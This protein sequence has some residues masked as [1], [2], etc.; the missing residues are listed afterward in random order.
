MEQKFR[1]RQCNKEFLVVQQNKPGIYTLKCPYCQSITR[2][3]IAEGEQFPPI[4]PWAPEAVG[5][6][7]LPIPT[8]VVKKPNWKIMTVIFIIAILVLASIYIV[9]G[10]LSI[11]KEGEV[12]LDLVDAAGLGLFC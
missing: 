6:P 5:Y 10:R 2:V 7:P 3:K 4:P 12:K 11:E 9:G 1:C 8:P